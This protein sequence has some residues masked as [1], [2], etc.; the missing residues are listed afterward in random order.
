MK[1]IIYFIFILML[2]AC[3]GNKKHKDASLHNPALVPD[4]NSVIVYEGTLPCA[5]CGGIKTRLTLYQN[6]SKNQY[7]YS[8]Q[9]VYLGQGSD[10]TFETKGIWSALKGTQQ[11]PKAIV[12]QLDVQNDD[13][14]DGDVINYLVVDKSTIKLI[15]N[16]MNEF[17][18]KSSY[19]LTRKQE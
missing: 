5:D 3:S 17:E 19:T 13:P 6:K 11:D 1:N 9:E 12:Y 15:D 8:L 2:V 4:T 10:K 18:S 14:E 16:E 7:T